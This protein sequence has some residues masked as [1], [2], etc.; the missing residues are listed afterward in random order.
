MSSDLAIRRAER[1][2]NSEPSKEHLRKLNTALARAGEKTFLPNNFIE[3][4]FFELI[5]ITNA[6]LRAPAP[7]S[8]GPAK[9]LWI[10]EFVLSE[11]WWPTNYPIEDFPSLY[12]DHSLES[13]SDQTSWRMRKN[14]F[15][16]T[17]CGN[18]I[19]IILDYWFDR[20]GDSLYLDLHF[21][22]KSRDVFSKNIPMSVKIEPGSVSIW[23]N[24]DLYSPSLISEYPLNQPWLY[25]AQALLDFI[26]SWR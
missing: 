15:R 22:R 7:W 20:D 2:L 8:S 4:L 6:E 5:E 26:C 23:N 18:S 3:D 1:L 17:N 9:N 13:R 19:T 11:T 10:G 21:T 16:E 12:E 25:D 14:H 24:D